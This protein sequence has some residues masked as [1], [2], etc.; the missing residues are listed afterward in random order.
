M[1][2][3]AEFWSQHVAAAKHEAIPISA[4]AKRQGLSVPSLYYW[5]RKLSAV[6]ATAVA[7]KRDG[8]KF[9]ALRVADAGRGTPPVG[10]CT[11]ILASGLRLEMTSLPAPEWLAAL[12]RATQGAL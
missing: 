12:G 5:H 8:G 7:N 6:T 4:Y 1:K 2:Q 3:G 9:M 10:G 11:L